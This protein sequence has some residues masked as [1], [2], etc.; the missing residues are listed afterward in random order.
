M[1]KKKKPPSIGKELA[2]A[3]KFRKKSGQTAAAA[4]AK[5]NPKAKTVS[6]A[7]RRKRKGA[8]RGINR[9]KK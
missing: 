2:E 7:I 4:K 8:G 9:G 1:A 5:G 3:K 6:Q